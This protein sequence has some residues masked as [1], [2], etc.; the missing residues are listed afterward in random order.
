M[1]V[2]NNFELVTIKDKESYFRCHLSNKR[3]MDVSLWSFYL[4]INEYDTELWIYGEKFKDWE[5]LTYDLIELNYNFS[6]SL[7]KYIQQF[8]HKEID[9][10][11]Y[12]LIN[13]YE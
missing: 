4:F 8:K 9:E 6:D 13:D 1:L 11:T 12:I 3:I 2:V 7:N 5:S 10:F